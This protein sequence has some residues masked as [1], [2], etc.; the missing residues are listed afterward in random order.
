MNVQLEINKIVTILLI[1]NIDKLSLRKEVRVVGATKTP[2]PVIQR[3][4]RGEASTS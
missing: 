3:F 1:E 2:Q 4:Y